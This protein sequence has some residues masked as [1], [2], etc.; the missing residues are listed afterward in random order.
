[1]ASAWGGLSPSPSHDYSEYETP[2]KQY[3]N[4][5]ITYFEVITG[6][7]RPSTLQPFQRLNGATGGDKAANSGGGG[8]GGGGA[9]GAGKWGAGSGRGKHGKGGRGGRLSRRPSPHEA[10]TPKGCLV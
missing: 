7:P 9:G 2:S 1:M 5:P 4:G 8:S 3:E 6:L 10:S